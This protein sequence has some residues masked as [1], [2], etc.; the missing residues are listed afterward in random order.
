MKF[1]EKK[2]GLKEYLE[3]IRREKRKEEEEMLKS[4][5]NETE[6]WKFINKKRKKRI[7][8]ENN[9]EEEEWRS[10][11]MSLLGGTEKT[12]AGENENRRIEE[13]ELEEEMEEELEEEKICNAVKKMK[14]KKAA[15]T[16]SI[17]MEA[18]LYG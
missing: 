16:D 17:P 7:Y 1:I 2:K 5:H 9:I 6:I 4:L 12:I 3:K 8:F 18:W 13:G 10:Y 14:T 15:V 11:F